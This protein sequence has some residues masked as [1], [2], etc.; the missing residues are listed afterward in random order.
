MIADFWTKSGTHYR[1]DDVA[2]T[3]ECIGPDPFPPHKIVLAVPAI[4]DI[5]VGRRR[6][7]VWA[8]GGP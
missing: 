7:A 8:D 6:R 4:P 3:L 1:A 2:Q 5:A